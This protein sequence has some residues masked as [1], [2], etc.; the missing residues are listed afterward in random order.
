MRTTT[1]DSLRHQLEH[2][3]GRLQH[4]IADAGSTDDLVRLL[5]QVDSAL[6]KLGG[7]EFGRCLVCHESVDEPDLL[8]NPL[9]QYCLCQLTPQQQDALQHDLELAWRIQSALLPDPDLRSDGWSVH[10]RY[11]PAGPVSGD[12]CDL[13]EA[14]GAAGGDGF[15]FFVGDVSG[16]GVAASLLMA[17]LNAAFRSHLEPGR[18]LVE[19]V[20]RANRLFLQSTIESHYATLVCGRAGRDGAVELVNAGHCPPLV[21]RAGSVEPIASTGFPIG[22]LEGKPYEVRRLRLAP[23]EALFLYTDGLTEAR[24]RD[25]AE[26][27]EERLT[28]LLGSRRGLSARQLV[29]TCR[30][31]LVSFLAGAHQSDDLTL[32]V[33]QRR[34]SAH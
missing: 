1:L 13:W 34:E 33:L 17:H 20:E 23:G 28:A 25:G 12:Y 22:I 14:P 3:R 6:D 10:Y 26:Y 2:R 19:L 7:D 16:K 9:A 30:A 8:R 29:D 31:D 18:P 32:M 21:L 27:G 24:G 11:E 4:A 15:H 5:G